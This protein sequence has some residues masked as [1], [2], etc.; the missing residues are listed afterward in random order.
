MK[1]D[2][3]GQP[4]R[5]GTCIRCSD[6]NDIAA[7][8]YCFRCY[9][10]L[11]REKEQ[12]AAGRVIDRHA[13]R[14]QKRENEIMNGLATV[15]KGLTQVGVSDTDRLKIRAIVEPYLSMAKHLLGGP[16]SPP[17]IPEGDGDAETATEDDDAERD[18]DE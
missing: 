18:T 2:L 8:G 14:R 13:G 4:R 5:V 6:V 10:R 3:T 16:P 15:M 12:Q 1:S 11:Q 9:R 7:F 17:V